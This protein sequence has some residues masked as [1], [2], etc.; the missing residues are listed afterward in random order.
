MTDRPD[1]NET[2]YG[3]A[4]GLYDLVA[5]APGVQSWRRQAAESLSL[6]PGE[7]VVEVGCGTGSNFPSRRDRVGA[8]GRVVGVDLVPAMLG[9]AQNRIERAGW[10]NVYVVRGD[11]TRPPISKADALVSTFVVGMLDDPGGAVREWIRCVRPGGRIT[12]LNAARTERPLARPLNLPL[13]LFVRL[14]APGYRLRPGSP[15]KALEQRWDDACDALFEGTVDH[16]EERLGMGL[17][18]LASGR[19]PEPLG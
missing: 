2:F 13:R 19:V 15:T 18:P 14:T 7:T 5:S 10:E 9:E 1:L 8:T 4:A 6:S 12:L 17:V 11:A 16:H 3:T